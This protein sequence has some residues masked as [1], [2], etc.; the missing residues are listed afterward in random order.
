MS[1]P[2]AENPEKVKN[3][4]RGE[5]ALEG[6]RAMYGNLLSETKEVE[7]QSEH[8]KDKAGDG[9]V[10]MTVSPPLLILSHN[11]LLERKRKAETPL[12]NHLIRDISQGFYCN[13]LINSSIQWLGTTDPPLS[14]LWSRQP[15]KRNEMQRR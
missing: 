7:I 3:I 2:G 8:G 14:V 6:F 13:Y 4:V 12:S 11:R 9:E 15:S 1:V 5:G 10:I